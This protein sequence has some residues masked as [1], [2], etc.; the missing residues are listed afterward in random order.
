V[1]RR[2]VLV[3]GASGGLGRAISV[4]FAETGFDVAVN[5]ARSEADA[6]RTAEAVRACG[7]EAHVVQADVT[8]DQAVRGMLANVVDRFGGLDVLVNNAGITRYVPLADLEAIDDEL[9]DRLLAVNLKAPFACARAAAPHLKARQGTIV[10]VSSNSGLRP[11]GSSIPYMAS[12]AGLIMLTKCLAEALRPE[13]RANAVA[14]G[15]LLT[16]W[17][18]KYV[19]E[20]QRGRLFAEDAPRPA[21][22]QDVARAVLFLAQTPSINGQT[23]IIDRGQVLI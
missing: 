20:A 7:A 22:V 17:V 23:L 9:W 18:D 5:Y 14:P 12:K 15:W 8:D 21:E 13:V 16:P 10:N 6:Q 4:A 11:S 1:S 3:T 19:P 2:T